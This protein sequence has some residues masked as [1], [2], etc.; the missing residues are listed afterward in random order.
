MT[1]RRI[2]RR[3]FINGILAGSSVVAFGPTLGGCGSDSEEGGKQK[4]GVQTSDKGDVYELCHKLRDGESWSFPAASGTT[5]DCVVIGAGISGLTAAWRLRAVGHDS[6]LVLDKD[7]P[8]GGLS[9]SDG[10]NPLYSQATAYTVYPYNDNLY[11]LYFDLGIVTGQDSEGSAIVDPKYIVAAPA[12]NVYMDGKWYEDAWEAGMDAL[13]LS[14][15]ALTDL[16]A[17]RE[18]MKTWYDFVGTD[19]LTGFDTPS[20]ASTADADVR[21]LD[22]ISLSEYVAQKGWDPAVS[23]FWDYYSRSAFGTT[24]EKLSAWAAI[25]F[26]GSEF[27]PTLTQ[28]GGNAYIA[29][30]LTAKIGAERIKTK[31]FVAQAKIE[32]TEVVV[33]YLE[34]GVP[35]SVKAKTVIYAAPRY[36]A[37]H[38]LPDLVAAGRDEGS[39]FIYTP[40]L[41]ANVRVTETPV[42]LGY[43]NWLHGDYSFTD[44]IVADWAGL[45]DPK[46]ADPKR[47]NVL[48]LYSPQY[49]PGKRSELLTT[50]LEVYEELLLGDLEKVV[51]GI[52]DVVTEF[53]LYRW[54][55]AMLAPEKGFVFGADR[56]GSQAPVDRIFFACNDVDGL[57]AFENAVAAAFRAADEA[58]AM[59]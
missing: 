52:R 5:Y 6:I 17:F 31:C 8:A 39:N 20:D 40:Y 37:R 26:L 44:V 45:P 33:S 46:A 9:R 3:D 41:V 57:P 10:G 50:E 35:K 38:V 36:I 54:G 1:I 42:E 53:N 22:E 32:G 21:A 55:H 13:P 4:P 18:D 14:P 56:V 24:H 19:G 58:V 2:K 59:M 28:P 43:D 48:T 16:K 34:D 15:K 47:D 25:N 27:S 30:M 12:N 11:D 7:D 29:K 23:Q 51:P 49:G